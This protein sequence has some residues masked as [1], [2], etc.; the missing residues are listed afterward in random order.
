[1]TIRVI[2]AEDNLLVR[3]G[4]RRLLETRKE[5]TIEVVAREKVNGFECYKLVRKE[6]EVVKS[7]EHL[8]VRYDGV[9]RV[10]QDGKALATPARI[11]AL[12]PVAGRAWKEGANK[13]GMLRLISVETR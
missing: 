5:T 3:E 10:A 7:N 8:A 13:F 6:E 9:Y 1:M 11:L 2:L 12:P 4:V